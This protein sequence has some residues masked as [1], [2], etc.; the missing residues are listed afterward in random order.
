MMRGRGKE[1]LTRITKEVIS[2]KRRR[3]KGVNAGPQN[4][5]REETCAERE[6]YGETYI[7]RDREEK[8]CVCDGI[9]SES[10]VECV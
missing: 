3:L 2:V 6:R 7:E 10:E 8:E 9:D 5:Q 4:R 1:R